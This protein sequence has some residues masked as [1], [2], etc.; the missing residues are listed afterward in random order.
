MDYFKAV[1]TDFFGPLEDGKKMQLWQLYCKHVRKKSG[2]FLLI[3]CHVCSSFLIGQSTLRI[4]A[5]G[6][7]GMSWL[8]VHASRFDLS[9]STTECLQATLWVSSSSSWDGPV[10][11]AS[12]FPATVLSRFK[13]DLKRKSDNWGSKTWAGTNSRSEVVLQWVSCYSLH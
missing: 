10:Y 13:L 7:G 4:L 6:E 2:L 1:L 11:S 12:L 9:L 8:A 3:W 5:A